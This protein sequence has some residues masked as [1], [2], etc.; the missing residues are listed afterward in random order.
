MKKILRASLG[1]AA[2][3]GTLFLTQGVAGARNLDYDCA[4]GTGA[5]GGLGGG[6]T[7]VASIT[8]TGGV[9]YQ[10]TFTYTQPSGPWTASPSTP[11]GGPTIV[12]TDGSSGSKLDFTIA[13]ALVVIDD[14]TAGSGNFSKNGTNCPP[15]YPLNLPGAPAAGAQAFS[16]PAAPGV[17]GATETA[18]GALGIP[19]SASSSNDNTLAA[20]G[21]ALLLAGAGGAFMVRRRR[22]QDK[23]NTPA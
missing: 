22:M 6:E 21:A 16:K 3:I 4:A 15:G 19:A 18:S 7:F 1:A 10:Y 14:A 20:S 23:L 11:A 2:L 17:A 12:I 8:T 9:P 13:P 5:F